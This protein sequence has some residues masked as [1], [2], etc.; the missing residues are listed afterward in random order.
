MFSMEDLTK[1]VKLD[2]KLSTLPLRPLL[3]RSHLLWPMG[4][5]GTL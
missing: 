1:P 2:V 4:V 5:M 3:Q